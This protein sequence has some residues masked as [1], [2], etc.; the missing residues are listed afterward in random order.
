MELVLW[1]VVGIAVYIL[2]SCDYMTLLY[3]LDASE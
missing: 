2:Q 3:W 1:R